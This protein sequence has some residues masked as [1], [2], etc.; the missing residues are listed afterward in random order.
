MMN[1][2][3]PAGRGGVEWSQTPAI[4]GIRLRCHPISGS[5]LAASRY[6]HQYSA[7]EMSLHH[8]GCQ[9]NATSLKMAIKGV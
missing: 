7:G 4:V 9:Q 3:R 6:P 8:Q 2:S 5:P 1:Q